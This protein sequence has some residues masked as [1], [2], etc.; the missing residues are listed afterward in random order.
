[1]P[2]SSALE[3]DVIAGCMT[4]SGIHLTRVGP[5][6]Y[7]LDEE[8]A[9]CLGADD[10]D[11]DDDDADSY[12]R[13][14]DV[15]LVEHVDDRTVRY[16]AVHERGPYR[17]FCF[18]VTPAFAESKAATAF[19]SSVTAA[20]GHWECHMGGLLF[21]AVPEGSDLEPSTLF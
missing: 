11:D 10:D 6:L 15:M 14:G 19:L 2:A 21:I 5:N 13:F 17:Q 9:L 20:G 1:M 7:R 16:I 18:T 4:S 3:L 12:P 8:A